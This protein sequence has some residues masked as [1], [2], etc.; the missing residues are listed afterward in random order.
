MMGGPGAAKPASSQQPSKVLTGDL[1]SSLASL[2]MNL[3]INKSQQPKSGQFGQP[4]GAAVKPVSGPSVPQQQ[5]QQPG[6]PQWTPQPMM[7]VT[8]ASAPMAGGQMPFRPMAMP[9][10]APMPAMTAPFAASAQPMNVSLWMVMMILQDCYL[11][12]FT[13]RH[14]ARHGVRHQAHHGRT[15]SGL[16]SDARDDG[17]PAHRSYATRDDGSGQHVCRCRSGSGQSAAVGS[18]RSP[19]ET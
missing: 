19:L 8:M 6:Q 16:S 18:F 15:H 5:Q 13:F 7:G 1:D 4:G 17:R 14:L 10:S 3:N 12:L 11:N 9:G 2:A